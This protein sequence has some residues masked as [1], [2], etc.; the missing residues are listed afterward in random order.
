MIRWSR[1][2]SDSAKRR[3]PR[4]EPGVTRPA[5]HGIASPIP[6]TGPKYTSS[7]GL[8]TRTVGRRP[9]TQ[10]SDVRRRQFTSFDSSQ[11]C[12]DASSP[13]GGTA[14]EPRVEPRRPAGGPRAIL[15]GPHSPRHSAQLRR[16]PVQSPRGLGVL[17]RSRLHR[18][19]P[20]A[21]GSL[22]PSGL[23]CLPSTPRCPRATAIAPPTGRDRS[24]RSS[25]PEPLAETPG[26][27]DSPHFRFA[28]PCPG[29]H[30]GY[31]S[32]R[33]AAHRPRHVRTRRRAPGATRASAAPVRRRWSAPRGDRARRLGRRPA[34][35]RPRPARFPS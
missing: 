27:D 11:P 14:G 9:R 32:G 17:H 23:G 22:G 16:P 24:R 28:R 20:A 6:T 12:D 2:V 8:A 31:R 1:P 10:R 19:R 21:T 33:L 18:S 15:L 13:R 3:R 29:D 35:D 7:V 34:G 4:R 25:A 26:T 5:G 30:A